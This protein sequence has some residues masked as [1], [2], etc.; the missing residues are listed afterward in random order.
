MPSVSNQN[1]IKNDEKPV[2]IGTG[3]DKK[4]EEGI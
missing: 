1:Q 3:Q 2:R 4:K